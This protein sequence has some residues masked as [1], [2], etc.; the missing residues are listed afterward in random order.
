M[1][2]PNW[3]T[4]FLSCS[5][6]R[7]CSSR[8]FAFAHAFIKLLWAAGVHSLHSICS[9]STLTL[10]TE[11]SPFTENK[12]GGVF[13]CQCNRVGF[14]WDFIHCLSDTI[15]TATFLNFRRFLFRRSNTIFLVHVVMQS[16]QLGFLC[17]IVMVKY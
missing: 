1:D 13:S 14:V 11:N 3:L 10:F 6:S 2:Q 17:G 8:P 12:F 7:G 16:S 4:A 9:T 5:S 15:V